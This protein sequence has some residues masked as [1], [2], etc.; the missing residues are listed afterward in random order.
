[1]LQSTI[2]PPDAYHYGPFIPPGPPQWREARGGGPVID[3]DLRTNIKGL[4]SAG[5][6][7][8]GA[9]DHA[10]SATMGRYAGRKAAEYVKSASA[11]I[12]S[13]QQVEA[14]KKRVYA[15]VARNDGIGWKELKAGLCRIMQDYCGEYKSEKVL[16]RGLD[17]FASIKESEAANV[18]ARNPHELVRSLECLTHITMGEAIIH[19]CLARKSS[20]RILSFKRLDYPEVDPEEWNKF[21]TIRLEDDGVKVGEKPLGYWLL[22]PYSPDY[23]KNY[24][25]HASI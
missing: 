9:A 2:L 3:W 16:R 21:V 14:E 10:C 1:M 5:S 17:W 6:I 25:K 7:S 19:A 8:L 15:P 18:Y 11:P 23:E 4:Y 22:P 20:S 13:N 24:Q 12:V